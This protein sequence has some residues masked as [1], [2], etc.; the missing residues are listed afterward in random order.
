[1]S[2]YTFIALVWNL[3][4]IIS[5]NFNEGHIYIYYMDMDIRKNR[6]LHI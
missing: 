2:I 4:E 5:A 1:M 6:S 3:R